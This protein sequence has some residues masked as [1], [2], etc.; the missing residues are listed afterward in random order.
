M[1]NLTSVE[2]L[3]RFYENDNNYFDVLLITYSVNDLDVSIEKVCF[4]PI[5]HLDW[6]CL[7]IGA[8]GWGQIKIA[9]SNRVTIDHS[10]RRR[11][12]MIPLC[13]ILLE[14]YPA[15]IVKIGK[16]VERFEKIRHYWLENSEEI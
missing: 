3:T 2:R 15:E 1:P 6:A 11:D 16:R 10:Q 9:N 4:A 5:E 7:T 8:L 14:F 12:W 13:D